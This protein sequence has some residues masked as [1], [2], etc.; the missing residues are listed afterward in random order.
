MPRRPD[1]LLDRDIWRALENIARS[2]IRL[3]A[4]TTFP[5]TAVNDDLVTGVRWRC[6]NL[7]A[8][9]FELPSPTMTLPEGYN[10]PD[11]VLCVWPVGDVREVVRRRT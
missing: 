2:D 10:R 3:L 4:T 8:A 6:L 7:E 9:P 5:D 1:A 11:Q